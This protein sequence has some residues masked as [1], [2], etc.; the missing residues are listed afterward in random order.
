MALVPS[1]SVRDVQEFLIVRPQAGDVIVYNGSSWLNSSQLAARGFTT[2]IVLPGNSTAGSATA[3]SATLPA[4]PAGFIL[5][6]IGA[7]TYKV[8]YYNV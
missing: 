6:Q 8:P 7:A 3:G 4:N 1:V 5:V 2:G